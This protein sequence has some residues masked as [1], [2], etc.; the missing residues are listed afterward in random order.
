[1]SLSLT[2]MID[3]LPPPAPA[4]KLDV[5]RY[6]SDR[7]LGRALRLRWSGSAAR[8]TLQVRPNANVSARWRTVA[9]STTRTRAVFVGE[10][11]ESYLFR[12][13]GRD[14]SGRLS[15]FDYGVGTVPFDDPF[16]SG[17]RIVR[18]AAWGRRLVR[19]TGPSKV[20]VRGTRVALIARRAPRGA[21]LRVTVDGRRK[22]VSLR[23]RNRFRKVVFRSILMRPGLHRFRV[24]ALSE[25]I[26]DLDALAVE[27]GPAAP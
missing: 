27:T 1:L 15:A 8:F 22:Q 5:P 9:R 11:G 20:T 6:A 3:A 25:G 13:R 16:R 14:A 18:R 2:A 24:E 19:L 21:L 4:V 7:S 26:A 17:R 10:L 23:G 12:L